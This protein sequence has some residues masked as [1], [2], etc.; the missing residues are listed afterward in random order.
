MANRYKRRFKNLFLKKELQGR[1]VF[2]VF[3]LYTIAALIFTLFFGYISSGTQSMVYEDYQLKLGKTPL[4][5]WRQMIVSNWIF[6]VIGGIA[7]VLVSIVLTHRFAGPLFR[8]EKCLNNMLSGNL[9]DKIYLRQ[10]DEAKDIGEKFNQFNG[11]LSQKISEVKQLVQQMEAE[12]SDLDP[13]AIGSSTTVEKG[14]RLDKLKMS[15]RK[16]DGILAEFS[17]VEE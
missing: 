5:L 15:T 3:L 1:Y 10:K 16:I 8:F 17:L 7:L 9:N 12:L 11:M 2:K 4:I 13:I 6:I 14:S